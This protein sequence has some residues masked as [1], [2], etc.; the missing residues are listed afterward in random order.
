MQNGVGAWLD[1]V[2]TAETLLSATMALIHP[3]QHAMGQQIVAKLRTMPDIQP[4]TH[5]WK[6]VM[7]YIDVVSNRLTPAHRNRRGRA[8]WFD[9]LVSTGDSLLPRFT[10]GT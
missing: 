4:I 3:H 6:S 1:K 5:R 2:S 10:F 8:E 9:L 7:T